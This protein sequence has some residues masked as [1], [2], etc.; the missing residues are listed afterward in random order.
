MSAVYHLLD[1]IAV[2][3]AFADKMTLN[4]SGLG[5]CGQEVALDRDGGCYFTEKLGV[6]EKWAD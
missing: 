5:R 2:R 6:G 1:G 3:L 4:G